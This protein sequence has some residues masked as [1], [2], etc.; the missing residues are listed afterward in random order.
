MFAWK[1]ERGKNVLAAFW[2]AVVG[3]VAT[4]FKNQPKDQ[5]AMKVPISGSYS[6]STVGVW[7]ATATLLQ[8]AF[9]HALVPKIDEHVTVEEVDKKA[10]D[11]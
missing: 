4:V 11:L 3:G 1:K 8:N 6:N 2:D 10:E 9:I 5:L 7:T